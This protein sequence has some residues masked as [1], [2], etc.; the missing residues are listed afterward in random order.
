MSQHKLSLQSA[1]FININ[2]M[3]GSGIFI[4]STILAKKAGILGAACYLIV[5]ALMLP[6]ILSISKLVNIHPSGGFY[7]FGKKEITPFAGFISSW[8]YI[9]GK[10]AA[11]VIITQIAVLLLQQVIV[12]LAAIPSIALNGII[13]TCFLILNLLDTKSNSTIQTVFF[14]LKTTPILFGIIAGLYLFDPSNINFEAAD[15]SGIPMA[16]PLVLFAL[17][18][19]EAACSLSS[20]I[21]NASVNAPRAILYSY[22]AVICIT[23]LFQFSLYA[24]LGDALAQLP[25]YRYLFPALIETMIPAADG[26][27]LGLVGLLHLAVAFSALGGSY[28]IIFSNN[29]NVYA[30]AQHNHLAA[31]HTLIKMNRYHI[32]YW[33]VLLEGAIYFL[34]LFIS[35]GSQLPLQQIGAFGPTVAYVVSA[36]ASFFATRRGAMRM[37]LAIPLLA[38]G[39]TLILSSSAIYSLLVDGMSSLLLFGTLLGVGIIMF[40]SNEQHTAIKS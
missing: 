32:P 35:R 36:F 14:W 33:C 27:K 26:I 21:E 13:I 39:S 29:W 31:S 7:I 6:L 8:S 22:G 37:P 10:L 20:H 4:N 9:I 2:I 19:F 12:P 24:G 25:D 38:I 17:S 16:L 30:L 11:A 3:L 28:G 34:F 5:G 1:L 15:F 18:G 23:T 40:W